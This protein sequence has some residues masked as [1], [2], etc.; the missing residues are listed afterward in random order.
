MSVLLQ[1]FCSLSS[2]TLQVEAAETLE[3]VKAILEV[4]T[5]IPTSQQVLLFNGQPLTTG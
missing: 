5:S 3:N 1:A 4:E 2:E